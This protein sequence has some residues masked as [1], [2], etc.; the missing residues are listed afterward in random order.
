MSNPCYDTWHCHCHVARY[1][2]NVTVL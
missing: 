2:S 1:L